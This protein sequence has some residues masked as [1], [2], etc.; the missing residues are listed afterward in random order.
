M[1]IF[2]KAGPETLMFGGPEISQ[3]GGPKMSTSGGPKMSIFGMVQAV[4]A[5]ATDEMV[6][7]LLQVPRRPPAHLL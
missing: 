3:S 2:L 5:G 4:A 7:M 1:I 6:K